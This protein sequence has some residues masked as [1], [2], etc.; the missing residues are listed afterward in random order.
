MPPLTGQAAA[1]TRWLRERPFVLLDG[2][3]ATTLEAKGHDLRDP[4]WSAR[5]L[6]D[7]PEAIR[8]VH[9]EFL[10]A[11]A[12][13]L[14]TASYQATL[15]GLERAGLSREQAADA[16]R[17]SV[18]LAAEA[19]AEF[20]S[21][22]GSRAL[23]AASIGPYGAYLAN[24]SE[25]VGD[26]QVTQASLAGFHQPRWEILSESCDLLA[27]ETLPDVA[28]AEVLL[29]LLRQSPGVG[30]W[31]SFSC[32]D[33]TRIAD[34]TP[35]VECAALCAESDQVL[36]VGI[37]CSAPALIEPLIAEVHRGAPGK[38]VVVYPNSG[39]VYDPAGR[40]WQPGSETPTLAAM[41]GTWWRAG[42]RLIGG[43]CRTGPDDIGEL[44]EA[45]TTAA[46]RESP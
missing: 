16:L 25:Y 8:Q 12:D 23:V 13:C 21:A 40:D 30:A 27:C 43:C 33:E 28:E 34:G 9:R 19:V 36:A 35:L 10:Q 17:L 22:T 18:S 7:N 3:L 6:R 2:G 37:N 5:L 29:D 26:Y 38:P 39:E 31:V 45:L 4:L 15:S 41:A 14:V 20:D 32:R 42:A 1:L 11:G 44:R 24:G 46:G